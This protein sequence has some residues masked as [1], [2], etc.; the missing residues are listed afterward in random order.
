MPATTSVWRLFASRVWSAGA[1]PAA[2]LP[3]SAL[4]RAPFG[5]LRQRAAGTRSGSISSN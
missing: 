1:S 2:R 3:S 4:R 5:I